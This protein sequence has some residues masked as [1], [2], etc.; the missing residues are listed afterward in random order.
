M[1]F[2]IK[3]FEE[4][5]LDILEITKWYDLKSPGLG[6]RFVLEIDKSIEKLSNNP[7]LIHIYT[8]T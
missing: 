1:G 8:M 7:E 5:S 3:L 2:E 6:D 4:A